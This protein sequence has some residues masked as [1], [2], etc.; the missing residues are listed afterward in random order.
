MAKHRLKNDHELAEHFVRAV[1]A[2]VKKHGKKAIKW[3]GLANFATRDVI[4]MCWEGNSTLATEAI[5]RGY[6]TITCPWGLG[7]PWEQWSMY[8]C[9]A[10]Q[11]KRGDSVLGATLVAWEQ[12]PQTHITNLRNL[13]SRQERTWGPDNKMSIAGF[14][15]RFQPLDAVAGRLLGMP[16]KLQ[17]E[18]D[19]SRSVGTCD[20]LDP[21]F[22]F[23]GND[24]TV[25]QSATAPGKGDHFTV[26]LKQPRLIHAIEVLTGVNGRGLLNGG[27]VQVSAD[28]KHFTTVATLDRG[29]A[30]ALLK[31]NRV[32]AVRLRA[33]AAQS[34]PLIVRA[35]NLRL[36]VEVSGAVRNPQAVIGAGNVAVIKGDTE[37][38]GPLGGCTVPVIN[39]GFTLKLNS[40]GKPGNYSGP[41]DGSGAVEI[42]A[43]SQDSPLTLDGKAPNT[44]RGKW[45]VKAGRV[46]LA[47]PPG[48]DALGGTIIVATRGEHNGLVWNGNDQINDNAH[49]QLLSSD[50]GGA[51]LNLNGFSDTIGRLTLA[52]GAKVLTSGPHGGGVL[53]V[54]ELR[55]NGRRLP[56][57]VYT[58]SVYWLRGSGYV[59]VGDVK[60][61]DVAGT[62]D[63]P[64]RRIGAGNIAALKSGSTFTLPEGDCSVHVATGAFPL[65]LVAGAGKRRW[66]GLITGNGG[67]R[68]VA[69]ADHQ[70]LEIAG[71]P[72][73][74]YRGDTTL[75]RGVLKLSKPRN[76]TAIPGNLTLGGSAAENKDDGVIWDGDGQLLPSAVVTLQG[77]QPS[78][79]DLNGHT[80]TLSKVVLSKAASI[81]LGQ[82][83]ALRLKQLFVG[84]QRIKD[85]VYTVGQPWL[86]GTGKVVVD[87][88]V[89]VRGVIGSPETQIGP[90]NI[91]NLIGDTT[92]SYPASGCYLDV[93][94]NGFTLKL[95]SGN[96]NAFSCTGSIS[97]TGNVEFFMGPSYTGFKDA[98][99]RL[100]G[101]RPNTTT[102]KFF[103]RKGRVQ[104]EK[105][106]GVDA[107]SGDVI[108]GGQGFNDCLFWKQSDQLKDSVNITL[109]D[110]GNSGAA[111][112]DLN[113]C[114][115][116]AASLTMTAHNKVRTDAP[117]GGSGTLTVRALTIGG[118]KKPAGVYTAANAP[119][120]EGKGKV[121]VRP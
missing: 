41:I 105:P 39:R 86:A 87:A 93:I 12:P 78:F 68:I 96:G 61:V 25:F 113:G 60:R 29:E 26:T 53:T 67:V 13:P 55:F 111:Y 4:I 33:S 1:C 23:D 109:L 51:C 98:P 7:V 70:P 28:G 30:R 37:F 84:G 63:D 14:A 9:N 24:A 71:G 101:D 8:R 82:G 48:T 17:L 42:N 50:K 95:D 40:G 18:A 79:L 46:V 103:V 94:T 54:Q 81:R 118:I 35:V 112:L 5:A 34:E 21:V 52:A 38:A 72:T 104:L 97:G 92:I 31:E 11:L 114:S 110:A 6:T 102:G 49:I 74:S 3:E 44:M 36:M 66:N 20:F 88:R 10:S 121:I 77:S 65:T 90:G 64:N 73:N 47:K 27:Q 32:Q 85:G 2:L 117:E 120:I 69:A 43:G 108:V 57:G 22:A 59:V 56:E 83:G 116:T 15:A 99:L 76:A 80:V 106:R 62:V 91:A 107:I 119:W 115:E 19:F 75:A 16:V 89:D 45:L 100:G 58:S